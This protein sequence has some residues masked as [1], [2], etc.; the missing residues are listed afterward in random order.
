MTLSTRA[1]CAALLTALLGTA[2]AIAADPVKIGMI[3]TLST[4]GGY[5]GEDVRDG[6]KLAMEEEGGNKLGGVPVQLL[7]ED[8]NLKPANGKQIADKFLLQDKVKIFTGIIYTNVSLAVIPQIL[9]SGSFYL[10]PN[11]GPA[12]YAGKGCN[13]NLFVASWQTDNLFEAPGH[14]ATTLGFK[15]V[16]LL[17]P[18]YPGGKDAVTGFKRYYRGQIAEEI[19][20]TL[21]QSDYSAEIA[22]L[23]ASNADALFYFLPGGLGINFIKQFTQAGMKDKMKVVLPEVSL[24]ERVVAATGTDTLGIYGTAHWVAT[25]PFP[26]NRKFVKEFRDR[27]HRDPT[28][29]ASQGYDTAK[30]LASGLRAVNGDVTGKADAFRAALK[31]ADFASTRGSFKFN[32]NQFPIQDWYST[33]VVK[34]KDGKLEIVTLGRILKDLKDVYASQCPMT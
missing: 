14:Y 22:R 29:Y 10:S 34:R 12:Q 11:S 33:Q 5:L 18:N 25:L 4:A 13:K 8:D 27:Y 7:V 16:A 9:E 28:P 31:K 15:R 30:L 6:F 1:A 32:N 17:A 3:T 26:A 20:T 23:R 24:E 21:D 19:Y 2:P